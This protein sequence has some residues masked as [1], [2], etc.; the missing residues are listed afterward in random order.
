MQRHFQLWSS[1]RYGCAHSEHMHTLFLLYRCTLHLRVHDRCTSIPTVYNT[2]EDQATL[3]REIH[4]Q[5]FC[6]GVSQCLVPVVKCKWLTVSTPSAHRDYDKKQVTP[7]QK[8]LPL[9]F[10]TGN[11]VHVQVCQVHKIMMVTLTRPS[12]AVHNQRPGEQQKFSEKYTK[13]SSLHHQGWQVD[14]TSIRSIE[15]NISHVK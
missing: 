9:A 11:Y 1:Y 7:I 12:H 6:S 10:T 5:T 4:H 13:S 3:V 2:L 14:G 8:H 15:V